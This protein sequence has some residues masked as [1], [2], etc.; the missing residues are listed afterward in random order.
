[1]LS[2]P[3]LQLSS[4]FDRAITSWYHVSSTPPRHHLPKA[5]MYQ[6]SEIIHPSLFWPSGLETGIIAAIVKTAKLWKTCLGVR[7]ETDA[8]LA[9]WKGA[10]G[11]N[12]CGCPVPRAVRVKGRDREESLSWVLSSSLLSS[13]RLRCW[14]NDC[15]VRYARKE[16]SD[17]FVR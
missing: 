14:R 6:E 1:M 9:K 5:P 13:R 10:D 16:F 11:S 8:R 3:E 12:E 2:I 7:S 17:G 4:S 15:S